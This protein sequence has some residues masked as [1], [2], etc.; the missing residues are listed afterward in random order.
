MQQ[1]REHNKNCIAKAAQSSDF[2]PGD[3][4]Y[5]F[6]P[7]VQPG[8]STKLTLRWKNYYRVVSKL[9]EENYCIKN[10]QT[11]PK[12]YT[13]RTFVIVPKRTRGTE[14]TIPSD[15]PCVSEFNLKKHLLE[16]NPFALPDYLT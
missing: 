3:L 12:L 7:S 9:G 16:F 6:D 2:K 4:V 8:D 15:S 14:N 13:Q 11:S 10:M 5:Y 1:A